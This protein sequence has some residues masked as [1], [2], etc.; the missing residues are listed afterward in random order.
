MPGMQWGSLS[1]SITAFYKAVA[2]TFLW[3]LSFIFLVKLLLYSKVL[4]KI[5]LE[6]FN[7][8]YSS[9]THPA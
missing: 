2:Q 6:S 3:N 9:C 1:G 7:C 8:I 4:R 5:T